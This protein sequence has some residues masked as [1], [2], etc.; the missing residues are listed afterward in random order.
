MLWYVLARYVQILLGKSH[1][2]EEIDEKSLDDEDDDEDD[3][4]ETYINERPHVHLTKMELH[5]LKVCTQL[6][7]LM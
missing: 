5:G 1:I 3:D 7:L 4:F 2:T 6:K